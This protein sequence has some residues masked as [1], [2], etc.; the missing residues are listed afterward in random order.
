MKWGESMKGICLAG[1]LNQIQVN[2]LVGGVIHMFIQF[3][4]STPICLKGISP[5][6][7][8]GPSEIFLVHFAW[9]N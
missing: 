8:G 5:T 9:T 2:V 1:F 7:L 6:E 3:S 4:C